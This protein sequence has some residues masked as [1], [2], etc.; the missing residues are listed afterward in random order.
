[1]VARNSCERSIE[2]QGIS[3][4]GGRKVRGLQCPDFA[5]CSLDSLKD[6]F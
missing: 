4:A 2:T 3:R 5:H 6:D 1:V